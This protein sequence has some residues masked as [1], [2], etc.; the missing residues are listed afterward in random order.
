MQRGESD[1]TEIMGPE[2][3]DDGVDDPLAK[4]YRSVMALD[5]SELKQPHKV[6][7]RKETFIHR[8]SKA[9]FALLRDVKKLYR[10]GETTWTTA[11]LNRWI[12]GK[13]QSPVC[14]S[15]FR[16]FMIGDSP[17]EFTEGP[18]FTGANAA[19]KKSGGGTRVAKTTSSR[20]RSKA[21]ARSRD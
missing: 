8:C 2:D 1:D 20:K 21:A 15:Q 16:K 13:L 3:I 10:T 14:Y 5:L 11:E 12:N 4:L 9:D 7:G 6:N 19:A 17:Y 18:E